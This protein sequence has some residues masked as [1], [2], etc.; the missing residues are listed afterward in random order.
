MLLTGTSP[1]LHRGKISP[2]RAVAVR[3]PTRRVQHV[4]HAPARP[5]PRVIITILKS[6]VILLAA[7]RGY[8][9]SNTT[10]LAARADRYIQLAEC[11]HTQ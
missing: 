7:A 11:I 9:T 10:L 2:A 8:T 5:D 1:G 3:P 6:G 4:L